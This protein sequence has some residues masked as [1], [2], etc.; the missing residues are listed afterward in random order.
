MSSIDTRF[1]R[2]LIPIPMFLSHYIFSLRFFKAWL[3]I[4]VIWLFLSAFITSV[5]PLVESRR[6][7]LEI[8][9]G[10]MKDLFGTR[11]KRRDSDAD[12]KVEQAA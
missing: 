7:M 3:I 2:Q 12:N 9:S 8:L 4:S 5:L 10:A 1:G 6:A 11:P